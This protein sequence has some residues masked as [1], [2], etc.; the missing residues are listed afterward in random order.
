MRAK[1]PHR[2][3]RAIDNWTPFAQGTS[4][5]R[6]GTAM[7][8]KLPRRPLRAADSRTPFAQRGTSEEGEGTGMRATR[9][10]LQKNGNKAQP[11][12]GTNVQYQYEQVNVR[13]KIA[14]TQ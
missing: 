13:P 6:E 8:A 10:N 3:P 2:P 9:K 14:S 11:N 4:E 12:P 5:E 1:L 7:R